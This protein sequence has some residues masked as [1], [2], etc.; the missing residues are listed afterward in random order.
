MQPSPRTICGV[1]SGG[2]EVS[3]SSQIEGSFYP[4]EHADHLVS[5]GLTI[6]KALAA[7]GVA[8]AIGFG[9]RAALSDGPVQSMPCVHLYKCKVQV[10]DAPTA[11]AM[12]LDA[13]GNEL[14]NRPVTRRND[15]VS[16][17]LAALISPVRC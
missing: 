10:G 14:L 15:P 13:E 11:T 17:S 4:T 5:G 2:F 12:L 7:V 1:L 8:A 3:C 16:K 9:V 6:G